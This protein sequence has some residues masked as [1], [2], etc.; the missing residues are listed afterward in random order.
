MHAEHLHLWQHNHAFG[1]ERRR[2]G[3]QR[4]LIVIAITL[5]MML[6][7]ISTGILFGSMALLADGLHMASHAAALGIAA[8][9]YVYARQHA[10]DAEFSFGTG[11]INALAGFT[12]AILL[13]L[14]ALIMA[15]ESLARMLQ[16]VTIAFDQAI[17]VAI[18]G[19]IVNG[20]SV[21]ILDAGHDHHHDQDAT[22]HSHH[23]D[24]NLRSAYL[25]VLADAL[26]SLLAIFALLTGKYFGWVLLDPIIGVLGALL[27]A[28]WSWGLM[29]T[30]SAVLVDRQGPE[31]IRSKIRASIEQ[32]T[33]DRVTD[34]HLWSIG[35]NLYAAAISI[36]S[37][38]PRQPA[39]IKRMLPT[40]TGLAHVTI[41]VNPCCTQGTGT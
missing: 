18:I 1:Q 23:H 19:L 29:K 25:H 10:R 4:T 13:A 32:D 39:E 12:G 3:E 30:T 11:K 31:S 17:A 16:P 2:P 7:E 20:A 35:P 24:H 22:S 14:F 26:T 28:R 8:F 27:V 37:H 6:I 40:D 15:W 21:L 41:E 38:K 36:I 5:V 9:A 34:L 33:Q